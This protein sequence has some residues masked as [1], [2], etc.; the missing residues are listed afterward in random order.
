MLFKVFFLFPKDRLLV[1]LVQ[2]HFGA[3][4]KTKWE[5][6]MFYLPC[7]TRKYD[8]FQVRTLLTNMILQLLISNGYR[9]SSFLKPHHFFFILALRVNQEN[10]KLILVI[11]WLRCVTYGHLA[12]ANHTD[13]IIKVRNFK[14]PCY[15]VSCIFY[16][17]QSAT[18]F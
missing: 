6:K 1:A 12:N 3:L 13:W 17:L 5:I 11:V 7:L 18:T 15:E 8:R 2:R 9:T 10:C 16:P 14:K 4:C